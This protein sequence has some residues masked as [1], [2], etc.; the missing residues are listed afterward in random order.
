MDKLSSRDSIRELW[1]ERRRR[2]PEAEQAHLSERP[3]GLALSG[4]GIRSATFCF[5][6]VKALAQNGL[7]HRFDLLSTV[8]GGGY[9]GATVGMLFHREGQKGEAAQPLEV[10]RGLAGAETR[11][12]TAWLRANGRY[13]IPGGT[14]DM[15]FAAASFGRNL[16]AIHVELAF[17]FI[18]LGCLLVGF[19][20]AVWQWADCVFRDGGC[21]PREGKNWLAA[22]NGSA[23]LGVLSGWPTIWLLLPFIVWVGLVLACCFWAIPAE[24]GGRVGKQYVVTAVAM[25]LGIALLLRHATPW[26]DGQLEHITGSLPLP[27]VL[28]VVLIALMLAWLCGISMA[29]VFCYL[30]CP[31]SGKGTAAAAPPKPAVRFTIDVL[32]NRLTAALS[33]TLMAGLVVLGLGV[34]D[35]LAWHLGNLEAREQGTFGLGVGVLAVVLR[36]V[37]PKVA[38]LPKSLTPGVRSGAMGLIGYA[39]LLVLSMVAIFWISLVH[40]LTSSVLF[41]SRPVSLQFDPAWEW[42][43][44]L[45]IP[46]LLWIA[47]SADN[48]EFLNRSSLYLFYRARLVRSYLGATNPDRFGA[49]PLTAFPETLG[50]GAVVA[51][52]RVQPGDDLPMCQYQPH[53]S[54]GPVHLLNVCINQ[55]HDPK[56]CLFNRD[57][58]GLLLTVGPEGWMSTQEQGWFRPHDPATLTLG[59][60][61]AISGAAVA[62]GLGAST[63]LGVAALLTL[64]G[65]R[66]GYWWD[67]I[68][69]ED[70]KVDFRQPLGKYRQLLSELF[71]RFDGKQR[72]NWFLSD[73]GHFENTGVYPLLREECELIVLA[74]CGADPRY[75]FGDLENLLRKARI[76][77]QVDIT[78]LRPKEPDQ[79]LRDIF[80]SLNDVASAD[81]YACLALARIDYR[82]SG[83]RG[84]M[85][86]VKPNMCHGSSVDLVNFKADNPLFPQEPTTDQFFSEAQ[87][88]SYFQ[89]GNTIGKNIE[90]KQLKDVCRFADDCFMDDDGAVLVQDANGRKTLQFS[91]KRLSSR[92]A[93]T[94]V[95]SA[96]VSLGAAASVGLALWQTVSTELNENQVEGRINPEVL[97]SLSDLFGKSASEQ[98]AV[99]DARLGE[100]AT[101][102]LHVGDAVCNERNLAAFKQSNLMTLMVQQTK[103]SCAAVSSHHPSCQALLDDDQLPRCLQSE[104]GVICSPRYWARDYRIDTQTKANCWLPV[105]SHP[106]PVATQAASEKKVTDSLP[107]TDA[108]TTI[109]PPSKKSASGEV[110]V[111][112]LPQTAGNTAAPRPKDKSGATEAPRSAVPDKPGEDSMEKPG[113][114]VREKPECR[115]QTVYLQIYGPELRSQVRKLRRYWKQLGPSVPPIEDVWDTANRSGL[116]RPQ[117]FPLPTV[118]YYTEASY[119][120]AAALQPAGTQIEWKLVKLPQDRNNRK[121]IIEVWIPPSSKVFPDEAPD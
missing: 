77:L 8:S 59:S 58:K 46:T 71:G 29:F 17:L 1:I 61:V 88:E 9:I 89:L 63:R 52:N 85:V 2:L 19:D 13:L 24:T 25:V 35:Y 44:W 11:W 42:L 68:G 110:T 41:S 38:D 74:D 83:K 107:A 113:T 75:A 117:P 92:I 32:R 3:W 108:S 40:D 21:W 80:G 39:G 66:L 60:W 95:V 45:F 50:S 106:R 69:M 93:S 57:R 22:W 78:F 6:L 76:D 84:F 30:A 104:P 94:G 54:G 10:E 115:G 49:E 96:S 81:S 26:L 12:F 73:G 102:L 65:I 91:T 70:K 99:A 5:G 15:L 43:G 53:R 105:L 79:A 116:R 101:A 28:V 55:S 118:I 114:P 111:P 16:F 37:L 31:R 100:M 90:L 7:L 48:R 72:R 23:L 14:R 86:I 98:T 64:A 51:V 36:A 121:N 103:R 119:R 47:V 109:S 87:W 67:S 112:P 20:L 97:K 62:P 34:I 4:G 120:C 82:R 18:V 56:G 33:V 27:T